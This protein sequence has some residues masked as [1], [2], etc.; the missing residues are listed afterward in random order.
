M[1]LDINCRNIVHPPKIALEEITFESFDVDFHGEK[2][3]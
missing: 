2:F 3:A 1:R